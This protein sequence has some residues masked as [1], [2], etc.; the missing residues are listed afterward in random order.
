PGERVGVDG[1]VVSGRSSLDASLL[2]G[3]TL[4]Q[5]VGP[6]D[7]V[8][9][10][11]LNR[12]AALVIEARAAG[13]GTLLAAIVRLMEQ[14]EQSRTRFVALADRVARWYTPVVH[15]LAAGTFL[16]WWGLLDATWQQALV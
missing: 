1:V 2:T 16:L 4:P 11:T 10:G 8:H 5:G 3:E 12:D 7:A 13:A 6:G 15:L 9:A 14:A